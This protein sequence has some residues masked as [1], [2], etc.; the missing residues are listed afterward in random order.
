[1]E[2]FLFLTT[3]GH[4]VVAVTLIIGQQRCVFVVNSSICREELGRQ[5]F[6]WLALVIHDTD[7]TFIDC[8]KMVLKMRF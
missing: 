6:L 2:S 1:M 7:L 4:N 3:V 5:Q 8:S